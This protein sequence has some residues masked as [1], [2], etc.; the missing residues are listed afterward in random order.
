MVYNKLCWAIE[1]EWTHLD[2]VAAMLHDTDTVYLLIK[3][4]ERNG[5]A[6]FYLKNN[7]VKDGSLKTECLKFISRIFYLP[8]SCRDA[9]WILLHDQVRELIR[10]RAVV[11]LQA[12]PK[13]LERHL[14]EL[15][16]SDDNENGCVK[17]RWW[18]G[19][20]EENIR[21]SKNT[22]IL[23]CIYSPSEAIFRFGVVTEEEAMDE[24]MTSESFAEHLE[25]IHAN[26]AAIP[27]CRAYYKMTEIL[28]YY[29]PLWGWF[30]PPGK[31]N[32]ID[33]GASPGGWSQ[34]LSP[35]CGL[36]I[37]IDPGALHESVLSL[38]NIKHVCSLAGSEA[39]KQVLEGFLIIKS[40]FSIC[41]CDVNFEAESAADMLATNILPFITGYRKLEEESYNSSPPVFSSYIVLTLKLFKNPNERHISYAFR[42]ASSILQSVGCYDFR[43]VHLHA[44]SRN[45]RTLICRL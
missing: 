8:Y 5:S 34:A 42:T 13:S 21:P 16:I 18:T 36:V 20:L 39:V 26:L 32:A 7:I 28:D 14:V 15:L 6:I 24:M 44:N 35:I 10:S 37:A 40:N 29:L 31:P 3:A 12:S 30:L 45:E 2:R 19:F 43:M 25:C 22:H 1:V 27:V 33:V 11:K 41:V 17:K 38:S 9:E 23:Q 4:I